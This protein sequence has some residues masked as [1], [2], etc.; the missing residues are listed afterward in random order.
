[1]DAVQFGRWISERRRACGWQ[2]QRAFI[3][4]IRQDSLLQGAG[5]SEDFLSR[6]EAGHLAHPFRGTVRRRVLALAW[7]LCQAPRDIKAYL[8]AAELTNLSAEET[9]QIEQLKT[10][11]ATPHTP[12]LLLLPPR[13]ARLIG[14]ASAL[15]ELLN[16]LLTGDVC[17]I[18]G[19][20]G[21]GKSAL[22]YEA[23][24]QLAANERECLR[25]FPDGI[26][27]FSGTGRRGIHG[28][29]SLLLEIAAV[30]HSSAR[31]QECNTISN[32]D[33]SVFEMLARANQHS[34]DELDETD[35][36]YALDLARLALANK[37]ALLLIDDLNVDFP[38]RQILDVLLTH[39]QTQRGY[40][41]GAHERC[42]VL[43]TSRFIPP[44]ALV[45]SHIHLKPLP[46]DSAGELFTSLLRRP[47]A[48]AERVYVQEICA[49][50]G[51]LP[52]AIEAAANAVLT[53]G[54]PLPLL[55]ARVTEYP[56]DRLLDGER[57]IHAKLS[58]AFKCLGPSA[59][60]RFILLST[61]RTSS[62]GLDCAATFYAQSA[63]ESR[64]RHVS[65]AH[66]KCTE[67]SQ[68]DID[69]PLAQLASTAADMGQFVRYSLLDLV[70]NE[71]TEGSSTAKP[72]F[73]FDGT[74]YS[75]HPLWR[76]YAKEHLEYINIMDKEAA[77]HNIQAYALA[78]VERYQGDVQS[79]ERELEFLIAALTY[80]R[81]EGRH[82][83]SLNLL[84]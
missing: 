62:F 37:R 71:A 84:Q 54:I 26:A 35:L 3:E 68:H 56:L 36:A 75:L 30:F 73:H 16:N 52:L 28:C 58:D 63:V 59:Q 69:I 4:A 67:R 80:A 43:I 39:D 66:E 23:L 10:Y 8:R 19:M 57:E 29:V 81:K 7:L 45:A 31:K 64:A 12:S 5:I 44:P 77:Q 60:K 83:R 34:L 70:A 65:E 21:I 49:A 74:R 41:E 79:L 32:I 78:S 22:A 76:A 53:E 17:A 15:S 11:L 55:A 40:C 20:P 82:Q 9:D 47:L 27:T 25:L 13:P 14:Q 6:L 24:H 18:T 46:P 51:Y 42:V 61:L 2:S 1:M 33:A 50:V 38:L 72:A 48:K